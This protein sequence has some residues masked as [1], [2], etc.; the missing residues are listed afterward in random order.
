MI[1]KQLLFL[2]IIIILKFNTKSTRP[3]YF[4]KKNSLTVL[5]FVW[6]QRWE[7]QNLEIDFEISAFGICI[8][9]NAST[10]VEEIVLKK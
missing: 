9:T 3:N 5:E 7:L 8:R 6:I 10:R 1:K 4:Y 2:E